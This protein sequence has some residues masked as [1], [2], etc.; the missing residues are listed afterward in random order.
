MLD[1]QTFLVNNK[2]KY[3][4]IKLPENQLDKFHLFPHNLKNIH[5]HIDTHNS[6]STLHMFNENQISQ[7]TK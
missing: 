5:T 1:R 3:L 7:V 2:S 4:R 6:W